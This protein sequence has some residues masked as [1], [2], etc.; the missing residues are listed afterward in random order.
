LKLKTASGITGVK[1]QPE[2][3]FMKS[4][5]LMEWLTESSL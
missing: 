1:A 4:G 2:A 3:L 5:V